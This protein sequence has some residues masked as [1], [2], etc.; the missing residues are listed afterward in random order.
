MIRRLVLGAALLGVVGAAGCNSDGPSTS[1]VSGVVKHNGNPVEGA[2]VS[3]VPTQTTGETATAV[4]T[5]DASGKYV[6]S[7][8]AKDDG[9]IPGDYKVSITK[10][11]GGGQGTAAGGGAVST[12]GE[13]PAD[14]AGASDA[15]P[16]TTKNLLPA[17]YASADT[18]G[19]TATVGSKAETFDF[20]LEGQ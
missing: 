9:A 2:I 20:N 18:S 7:T 8:R 14:Y 17:K 13:M 11:E 19:L 15:P 4:G 12:D 3:F 1:P 5:T 6:L 10:I 16:P